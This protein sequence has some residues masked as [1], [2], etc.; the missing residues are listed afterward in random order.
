MR[1]VRY[2]RDAERFLVGRKWTARALDVSL[3]TLDGL[4]RNGELVPIRIGKRVLFKRKSIEN[5]ANRD[6]K[7]R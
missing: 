2:V 7:T 6:H 1:D 5:F 3:R 4:V